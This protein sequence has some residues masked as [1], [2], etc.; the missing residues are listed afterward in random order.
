MG[1]L[2]ITPDEGRAAAGE[3]RLVCV[4]GGCKRLCLY[5]W[6]SGV[7][8]AWHLLIC[9][10]HTTNRA[11]QISTCSVCRPCCCCRHTCCHRL[12]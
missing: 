5:A 9:S 8:G 3:G 12:V 4:S 10:S 2:E 11:L 6:L 1:L 7:P